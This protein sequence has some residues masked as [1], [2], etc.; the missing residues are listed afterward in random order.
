MFEEEHSRRIHMNSDVNDPFGGN[1]FAHLK[2]PFFN[3]KTVCE[4]LVLLERHLAVPEER[5]AECIRKH[6]LMVQGLLREAV[7]L[8]TQGELGEYLV[9][10]CTN[11]FQCALDW[12]AGQDPFEVSQRLRSL[13]AEC[14]NRYQIV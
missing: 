5:C 9:P 12:R 11:V 14:S 3:L 4:E 8:D 13:R 10:F 6:F 1:P 2:D 7:Q